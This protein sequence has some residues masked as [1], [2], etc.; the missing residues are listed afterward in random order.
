MK[1]ILTYIKINNLVPCHF[2]AQSQDDATFNMLV[3]DIMD[4]G[5]ISALTVVPM[6]EMDKYLIL[7]G[8]HR[9]RAAKVA[10]EEELPCL[11]LTDTKF[12]K[13]EV[14]KFINVRLNV[15]QGKLNPDKFF[16]LYN[17]MVAK[18]G[19]VAVNRF[20]GF[21]DESILKKLAFQMKK[22]VKETLP[23]HMH[24]R[25]EEMIDEAKAVKD[26]GVIVQ[27]LFQ[28]SNNTLDKGFMILTHG[29][30]EHIYINMT[31][32]TKKTM[33]K[34]LSYCA[35]TNKNINDF[36]QPFLSEYVENAIIG[37]TKETKDAE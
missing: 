14:Q 31:K 15:L 26:L 2:N 34:A 36:L 6:D 5:V 11:V 24:M 19:K 4:D 18:H 23:E 32:K 27:T 1:N 25:A 12:Q 3:E 7:S 16:K 37:L 13:E 35:A 10:E 9:W 30:Q 33:D 20:L 8:E 28:Q 22:K 21:A 17:P 29:S